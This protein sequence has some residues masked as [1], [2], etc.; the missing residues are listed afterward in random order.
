VKKLFIAY[1]YLIYRWKSTN[2]HGVHSPFVFSLLCNVIYNR[3][4]YYGYSQIEALRK[5]YLE[6]EQSVSCPEMGAGSVIGSKNVR[7]IADIVATAAKPRK[8]S[9]LLFRLVDHFQPAQILEL[10]TSS[11]ISTAAMGLARSASKISTLEG[12]SEIAAVAEDS[13]R[14]LDLKNIKIHVGNF[15]DILPELLKEL[16][17]LDLVFFDGNHRLEPTLRYF[18]MCLPKAGNNSVFI[19]DDIYWSPEMKAA[20]QKIKE[21]PKV[22]VTVDLFFMGLVFFRSEQ[23]KQHFIIRY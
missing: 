18:E 13:F 9:S 17:Q 22:T 19:F 7:Q 23:V 3:T 20:W 16:P 12:C 5:R 4:N 14:E 8:Y 10:G 1:N 21:H 2:E 11:G 15:D 6:S